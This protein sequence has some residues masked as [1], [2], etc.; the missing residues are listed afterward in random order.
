MPP[1]ERMAD[2]FLTAARY[3]LG[4]SDVHVHRCSLSH[5]MACLYPAIGDYAV[6]DEGD[7]ASGP[8]FT[9]ALTCFLGPVFHVLSLLTV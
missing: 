1:V 6:G 5:G 4:P 2:G 7:D 3:S 8:H 9:P